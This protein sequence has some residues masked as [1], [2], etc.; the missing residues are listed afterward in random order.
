MRKLCSVAMELND[1]NEASKLS[2]MVWKARTCTS[3]EHR[4]RELDALL[5]LLSPKSERPTVSLDLM[6]HTDMSMRLAAQR[7]TENIS[8]GVEARVDRVT[9]QRQ[10]RDLVMR[11]VHRT[12]AAV[13]PDLQRLIEPK[14]SAADYLLAHG[15]PPPPLPSQDEP[16]PT[17]TVPS[18]AARRQNDSMMEVVPSND[19]AIRHREDS[20]GPPPMEEDG[21][22]RL[23]S[24]RSSRLPSVSAP[25]SPPPP[26]P[27]EEEDASPPPPPSP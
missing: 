1:S 26:P 14:E 23:P 8:G 24:S 13:D 11:A 16:Q 6:E 21:D 7:A 25:A 18:L 12:D 17:S 3:A 4:E 27:P 5:A 15:T 2:E 20:I 9:T 19:E 10:N 22:A